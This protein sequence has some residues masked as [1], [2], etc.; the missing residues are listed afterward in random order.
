MSWTS[1]LEYKDSGKQ[2]LGKIPKHW[3]LKALKRMVKIINGAT[4][5][6]SQSEY[7]DGDIS[8]ATPD[9]LGELKGSILLRT[10]RM[11][12]QSGYENCGTTLAPKNSLILSTRAPIGHL[13]IAGVEICV[14]QG[15]H[16]LVFRNQDDK[17]YFYYL[18]LSAKSELES[19]GEGST[20]REL[21]RTEL[22][23]TIL[24]VPP[25][26][27]QHAIAIFLDRETKHIDDLI[28]KK[29]RQIKLLQEK[30]SALISH[31]VT[32]GLDRNVKMKDSGVEWLGEI[33]T[34]WEIKKLK[35]VAKKITVGI[36][37]TPSKYYIDS[38]VPCLRSLNVAEN[39]LLETNLVYI[40]EESNQVLDKSRLHKGDL[41]VVRTGQPGTTAVVDD[42]FDDANCIDLI[43]IR[44]SSTFDSQFLSYVM[45]SSLA[46]EQ[47]LRGS[48]GSI[49]SHFNI[50]TAGNMFV[51]LPPY[52]EQ[53]L[54]REYLD[55]EDGSIQM[56]SAKVEDS[57]RILQ[58]YRHSLI[59]ATVT[60]KID[61]RH[62]VS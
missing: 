25:Y 26:E 13:A 36:V 32:K 37:I 50:E 56:L 14:N 43:I 27:E 10:R 20:F 11:I 45:N 60:G 53:V 4:P 7:W 40:S 62:E 17:K 38:G 23:D 24:C 9:D 44:K 46:K 58:E 1:Y 18:V 30:R 29:Q 15:C 2:W 52:K 19:L 47:Y 41:V 21:G 55:R 54:I 28:E 49:Q 61:V 34:G 8:W 6:S 48:S 39:H 22:E 12:T 31:V 16:L 59:S 51:I 33:P 57:V 35:Y 42:V 3:E 5:K